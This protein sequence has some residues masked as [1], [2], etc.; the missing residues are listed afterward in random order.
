[1]NRSA[2]KNGQIIAVDTGT[3]VASPELSGKLVQCEVI[4]DHSASAD[5]VYVH[6]LAWAERDGGKQVATGDCK[7]VFRNSIAP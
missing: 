7:Y 5:Q 1:M 4:G 6:R 2:F 3:F